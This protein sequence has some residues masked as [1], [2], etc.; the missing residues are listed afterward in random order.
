MTKIKLDQ[1][2]SPYQMPSVIIGSIVEGKPNF[3]LC[4]WVSRLNRSPPTWM[5]SINRK[6]F[7][8]NGIRENRVF[9]M[10]FPSAD[11]IVEADYIG[12]TS[13]RNVDKS[14]L[15]HLF[16]GET[17]APMIEECPLNMEFEVVEIIELSDH[18]IVLGNAVTSY[19]DEECM[20]DDK[21]DMKKLNPVIYTGAAKQPTYW[22]L[23]EKLGDAFQL[24]ERFKK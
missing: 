12:T 20:I 18:F 13:G 15:F 11:L 4:T 10:N 2:Y 3:M 8:M 17:R 7:T 6:H 1:K 19:V 9:S 14:S 16:Y 23:G 22:T 5:A 21:L 24:G